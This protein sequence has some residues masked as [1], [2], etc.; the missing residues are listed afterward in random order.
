MARE[1]R[2]PIA[3]LMFFIAGLLWS[4]IMPK[5]RFTWWLE[6]LPALVGVP[7]LVLTYRWFRFT[8]LSYG[9]FLV[10]A[11]GTLIGGH[12]TYSEVPAFNWLRDG[13]GLERNYY[14]RVGHF[15]QGFCPAIPMR[16]LLV[17]RTRLK[18]GG[19]VFFL[20]T[21]FCLAL[22]ALYEIMEWIIAVTVGSG[23]TAFLGTQGDEWDAQWDMVL[24][25]VGAMISMLMFNKWHDR[26]MRRLA[27]QK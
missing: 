11:V 21:C 22:A 14:D 10:G 16:E 15:A 27:H 24:A 18:S 9:L 6:V 8:P 20:V 5:D 1:S 7:I 4:G 26:Q 17:R 3:L 13:F 25:F 12:Y 2:V 23:S 19:W